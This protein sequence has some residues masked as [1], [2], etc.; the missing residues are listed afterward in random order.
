M[1]YCVSVHLTNGNT[2][3]SIINT[4]NKNNMLCNFDINCNSI[5]KGPYHCTFLDQIFNSYTVT[6]QCKHLFI[7]IILSISDKTDNWQQ[8][9]HMIRTVITCILITDLSSKFVY[10]RRF[11]WHVWQY[12]HYVYFSCVCQKQI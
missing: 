9:C 4:K 8:M 7:L 2:I 6:E 10:N 5:C 3:S 12:L 11:N 1:C